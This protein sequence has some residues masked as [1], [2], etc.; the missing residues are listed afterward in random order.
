VSSQKSSPPESILTYF[1]ISPRGLKQMSILRS[2][3][4]SPGKSSVVD[5][6]KSKGLVWRPGT[7]YHGINI[8]NNNNDKSSALSRMHE[9]ENDNNEKRKKR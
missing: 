6:I 8:A 5:L 3:I 1:S 9:P 2:N 7:A 4:Q